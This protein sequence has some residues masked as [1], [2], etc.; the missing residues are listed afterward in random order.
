MKKT[1]WDCGGEA[2]MKY[3]IAW[4]VVGWRLLLGVV[5]LAAI[6]FLPYKPSFPYSDSLLSNL[7]PRWLTAWAN[8]DGVHYLTIVEKGY[9]GTG[10]IQAFFPLYPMLVSI[11]SRLGINPVL[12]GV[13]LSTIC[14]GL[15]LVILHKLIQKDWGKKVATRTIILLLLAPTAFF[16]TSLYTESLFLLLVVLSFY[17]AREGNFLKAGLV[18]ILA[19]MTKTIGVLLVPALLVELWQQKKKGVFDKKNWGSIVGSLLP[20][21]GLGA[22]MIYLQKVFGDALLF[23]HAQPQFGA[24]REVDK[25][26]LPYQ[27]FWRYAKMVATV[28]PASFTYYTVWLELMSA[29]VFLGLVI[30]AFYKTRR[31]YAVFAAL[32]LLVPTLT[33]T[34]TSLPRYVLVLFP[35]FVVMAQVLS[36]KKYVLALVISGILLIINTMLFIQGYWVA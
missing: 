32:A 13:I 16:F 3:K 11:V 33:G 36:G 8:F 4:W 12:V 24:Q 14:F 17:L 20:A 26:I 25:L 10:S 30:W 7:G 9:F 22:Y 28:E 23:L 29:V 18:G 15:A 6:R 2:E 35:A 34:F 5:A 27:V 1:Y 21:G 31:S 19:A